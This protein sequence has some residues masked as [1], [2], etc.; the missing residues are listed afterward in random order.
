MSYKILNADRSRTPVTFSQ[1]DA[2]AATRFLKER[3]EAGLRNPT[4]DQIKRA[5]RLIDGNPTLRGRYNSPLGIQLLALELPLSKRERRLNR[6]GADDG[7]LG[8]ELKPRRVRTADERE[9]QAPTANVQAFLDRNPGITLADA[10][11]S[12]CGM[13]G[14][15]PATLPIVIK[16]LDR[17]GNNND[18]RR[19]CGHLRDK[20]RMLDAIAQSKFLIEDRDAQAAKAAEAEAQTEEGQSDVGA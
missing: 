2:I 15:T 1:V 4:K 3:D 12:I 13:A 6:L 16:R 18:G 8:L 10:V 7:G 11:T 5:Q 19:I 9:V 17:F 20:A 14:Y